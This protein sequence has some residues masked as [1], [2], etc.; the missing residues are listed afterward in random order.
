MIL[1]LEL[2]IDYQNDKDSPQNK[3]MIFYKK[4]IK[5]SKKFH[6]SNRKLFIKLRQG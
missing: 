5:I 2:H 1:K 3:H 4:L 6:S